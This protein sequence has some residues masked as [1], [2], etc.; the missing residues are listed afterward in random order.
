MKTGVH[1]DARIKPHYDVSR[2]IDYIKRICG[3][4]GQNLK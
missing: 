2:E 4:Q 1:A 3:I